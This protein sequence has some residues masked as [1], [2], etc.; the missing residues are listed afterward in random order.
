VR[1]DPNEEIGAGFG[2]DDV[3]EDDDDL[4]PYNLDDDM[5]DLHPHAKQ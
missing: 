4:K 3:E 1:F 5:S 2:R